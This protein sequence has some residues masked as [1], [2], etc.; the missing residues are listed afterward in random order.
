MNIANKQQILFTQLELNLEL[1]NKSQELMRYSQNRCQ[2][3][4]NK[5]QHSDEELES[6]EALTARFARA[7]DILTQKVLTTIFL[8]LQETPKTF[9]DKCNL[10]EK[11]DIIDR[12]SDLMNI[13][14]LR[15]EIAHEY[16]KT[17]IIE[18]FTSI[19]EHTDKL[20]SIIVSINKYAQKL[21]TKL[22]I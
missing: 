14:E 17:D 3:V 7:A 8:L 2:T 1:L 20:D 21:H 10:A 9:I 5:D 11:L 18:L 6:C 12:A 19:F 16:R 15:N 4:I 22:F 13:R